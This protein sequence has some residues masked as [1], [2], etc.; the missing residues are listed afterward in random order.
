[1]L[2]TK[3]SELLLEN[4]AGEGHSAAGWCMCGSV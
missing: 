1:M 3:N 4:I 2:T